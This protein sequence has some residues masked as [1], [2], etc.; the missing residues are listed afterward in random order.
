MG[1]LQRSAAV[2]D[3]LAAKGALTPAEIAGRIDTPR[4]TIYRLGDALT[5]EG[6]TETQS[7]ARVRLSLRWLRL[8]DAARSAMSEWSGARPVLDALAEETGQT[9]LLCVPRGGRVICVHWAPVQSLRI[10]VLRP[11]R[12]LPLH[13]GAEGRA[14]LAFGVD[15]PEAHLM[16]APF[17]ALTDRTLVTAAALREDIART[18]ELGYAAA[19]E[20]VAAGLGSL[21]APVRNPRDGSFVATLSVAGLAP[22]L[23]ARRRELAGHLLSSAGAL[24]ATLP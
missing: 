24:A 1:I 14:A 3:L 23:T 12:S 9:V 8:A 20:D 5:L 6:L 2:V 7:G 11:G 18:R 21:A 4:P 22:E 16:A 15:D 10:L 17:P 19:H 13:A